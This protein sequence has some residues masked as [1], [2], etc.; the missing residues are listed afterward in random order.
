LSKGVKRFG[1]N[2][3]FDEMSNL[4]YGTPS[5]FTIGK[6]N[7]D[8]NTISL[9]F[10]ENTVGDNSEIKTR[11]YPLSYARDGIPYVSVKA[12]YNGREITDG[13]YFCV[14]PLVRGGKRTKN[15]TKRNNKRKS[16]RRKRTYRR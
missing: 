9:H 15:K 2:S 13:Y 14:E 12:E 10:S 1:R 6:V 8:D 3:S 4:R 16:T 7:V 11:E 5:K